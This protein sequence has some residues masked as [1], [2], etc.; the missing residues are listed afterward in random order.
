MLIISHYSN[1]MG[2]Y[3]PF[4]QTVLVQNSKIGKGVLIAYLNRNE[5]KY[6]YQELTKLNNVLS[7]QFKIQR[8][9]QYGEH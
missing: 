6:Y 8:K 4:I 9:L 5:H 1:N 7:P 2:R 3:N